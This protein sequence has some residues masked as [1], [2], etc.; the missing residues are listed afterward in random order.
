ME[1]SEAVEPT[2][3]AATTREPERSTP[4]LLYGAVVGTL[5]ILAVGIQVFLVVDEVTHGALSTQVGTWWREVTAQWRE[6]RRVTVEVRRQLPYVLF[7][8]H[9]FVREADDERGEP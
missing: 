5:Y 8:A 7:D 4:D 2:E 1:E 6:R 9:E 3:E